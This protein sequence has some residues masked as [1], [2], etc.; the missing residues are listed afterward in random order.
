MK[1][2]PVGRSAVV[3]GC[4]YAVLFLLG[5]VEGGVGSFQYGRLAPAGAILF[6]LA[7]LATCLLAAWGMRSVTGAFASAAGWVVASF[8]L[9]MPVSGGSVIIAASTAGEWYLYGGTVSVIVAVA[10]VFA[11]G[12][13]KPR[14]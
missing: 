6:C 2:M 14:R 12:S 13:V 10:A 11:I 1:G 9:S 8:V 5:A 7:I 4:A 3:T